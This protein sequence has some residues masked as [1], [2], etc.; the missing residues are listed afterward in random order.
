M[1]IGV[2]KLCSKQSELQI[3]HAIGRTVFNKVVSS[4]KNNMLLNIS[5][6]KQ[7]IKSTSDHWATPQ[8]CSDCEQLFNNQYENYSINALRGKYP[9]IKIINTNLGVSYR[10]LK[11]EKLILYF[12]SIFWRAAHSNHEAYKGVSIEKEMDQYLRGIFLN[13]SQINSRILNV[14][15][16]SL[17]DKIKFISKEGLQKL[18]ISPFTYKTKVNLIY[19]ML[20]EGWYVEIFYKK[21]SFKIRQQY[22]FLGNGRQ[23]VLVPYIDFLEIPELVRSLMHGK[24]ISENNT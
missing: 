9:S 16:R 10:G 1:V 5:P 8:L 7:V 19:V 15:I 18:I 11:Q 23:V 24:Y 17:S 14:R 22:G 6:R 13:D 3:S 2:C 21:P 12:L 20:F 4:T